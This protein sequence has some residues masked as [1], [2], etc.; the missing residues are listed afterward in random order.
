[1]FGCV[2]TAGIAIVARSRL[3][4]RCLFEAGNDF[5]HWAIPEN[6]DWHVLPLGVGRIE[7]GIVPEKSFVFAAIRFRL[8][9]LGLCDPTQFL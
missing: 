2:P 5:P 6:R 7:N 3:V 4:T 1:M 9:R 8:S